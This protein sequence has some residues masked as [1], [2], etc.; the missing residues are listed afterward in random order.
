MTTQ[1]ISTPFQFEIIAKD[2]HSNARAGLLHTPHGTIKTPVFMPVG[3]QATVKG[4]TPKHIKDTNAQII[5]S[6]TYH[7]ALRPGGALIEKLGGLHPF[8]QWDGPILTDSG[9]YQVFSL[10]GRRKIT[11]EGVTFQSHLDGS[12][13]SFT[14]KTVIDLQRQFNSDI[15]MPLDICSPY[16]SSEAQ[17][18]KDMLLTHQWEKEA[19]EYWKSD[20]RNQ[21]LFA[22]VQGGMY[23]HL[24]QESAQYLSDLQF[25]GYAIGGVSVGEPIDLLNEIMTTT[26]ALLPEDKP[27]YV[28]GIGLPENFDHAIQA[29]I[30]MFDCVIPTRLARH[31]QVFIGKE[32]VNIK[33]EE[34][35]EDPTPLDP[36]CPCYTCQQFSKA[37]LR[38]LY[39]A[40]E[41]LSCTLLS[42]HN[43]TA[44]V[45][46]VAQKREEIITSFKRS[47]T[48][49]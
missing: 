17:T 21:W 8:I 14:P 35:K 39:Q 7:L 1:N 2:P 34:F 28:M 18:R 13:H 49:I 24:R 46:Y 36:S 44:L 26:A 9:G 20:T 3:T 37:Y 5:L 11:E 31:G 33:R 30:D 16:P 32:R 42:I 41:I 38:H 27:R 4:M 23:P 43:V 47:A 22:I 12:R 45:Q 6:N 19:L 40:K 10:R 25:P 29:G 15:M 48:Q